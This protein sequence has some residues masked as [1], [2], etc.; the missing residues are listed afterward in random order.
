[1]AVNFFP[2]ISF[3]GKFKKTKVLNKPVSLKVYKYFAGFNK[4]YADFLKEEGFCTYA[5]GLFSTIDPF[6]HVN[7]LERANISHFS[8]VKKQIAAGW[9]VPLIKTG[10]G[11]LI[12][13]DLKVDASNNMY[14]AF[15]DERYNMGSGVG[16]LFEMNLTD[17]EFQTKLLKKR[18]F[19]EAVKKFGAL[20][21]DECFGF[22]MDFPWAK[23]KEIE[24][25]GNVRIYKLETYYE[26]L[27]GKYGRIKSNQ[28]PF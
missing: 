24:K 21:P 5:N 23:E 17:S 11:D 14:Y 13:C 6:D 22:P 16:Y 26:L 1:M 20:K 2:L 18:L 3:A 8:P 9:E 25:I 27:S 12:I 7:M 4:D 19:N 28:K 10:F 15:Y